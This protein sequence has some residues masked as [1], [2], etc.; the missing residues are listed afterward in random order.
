MTKRWRE[1]GEG[2]SADE[3]GNWRPDE[4]GN[5]QEPGVCMTNEEEML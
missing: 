3:E 4:E 2:M 5:A 1:E